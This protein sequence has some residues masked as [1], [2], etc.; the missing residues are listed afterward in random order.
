MSNNKKGFI[1][2]FK[3]FAMRGNVIDLAVGVIIGAGFQRIVTSLVN[4]IIMPIIGLITGGKNFNE[5]FLILRMPEG[6]EKSEITSISKA[7][8]LKVTT[9]NYGSFI[10]S[11]IDFLIVALVIF[12]MVKAINKMTFLSKKEEAVAAPT[13][14]KCPFCQSEI[15]IEA[16]KCPHCTS[17]LNE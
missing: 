3:E 16:T 5:Q 4:D 10:S 17:D 8:E 7:A 6:I 12:I 9:F 13:T 2:E 15:A 14:K 11:V 1:Q